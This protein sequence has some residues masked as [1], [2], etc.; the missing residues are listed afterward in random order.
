MNIKKK[1]IGFF[2]SCLN[3]INILINHEINGQ[4]NG[5]IEVI[6]HVAVYPKLTFSLHNSL[7]FLCFCRSL[8]TPEKWRW[9]ETQG[10]KV[11]PPKGGFVEK[12]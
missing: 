11:L 8:V 9:N 2:I 6:F 4:N 3:F 10:T 5:K 1:F 7:T 12:R